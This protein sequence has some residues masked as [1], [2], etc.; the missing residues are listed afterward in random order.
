MNP[1]LGTP[2]LFW[3]LAACPRAIPPAPAAPGPTDEERALRSQVG[4]LSARVQ[5]LLEKQQE[6]VWK[7]WVTGAPVDVPGSYT[8]Q[9]DLFSAA[10]FR[11][12]IR[13]KEI[14]K[15]PRE[16][17]ALE[18]L[19][20]HLAG[21]WL[22]A[23]LAEQTETAANLEASMTFSYEGRDVPYR[24]LERLL[25]TE[26]VATRRRELLAASTPATERLTLVL[27]RKLQ[28]TD[29]L[30]KELGFASYEAFG[31]RLRG[32]RLDELSQ[33]AENVLQATEERYLAAMKSLT[34]SELHVPFAALRASDF[35]YLFRQR[36]TER[37]FPAEAAL[38]R[39]RATLAGL[40]I[41][42]GSLKNVTVDGE[43]RAGK[44]HATLCLPVRVPADVRLSFLP[45]AGA[46]AL[47][48]LFHEVGHALH[49]A[50]TQ[51]PRF[52]LARL[53]NT[54][55]VEALG[56]VF[57]DLV[58]DLQW[59]A[60]YAPMP[61]EKSRAH[62]NRLS[63]RRLYELRRNAA[64][65][66]YEIQLHRW[67]PGEARDHFHGILSRAL[68]VT[69]GAGDDARAWVDSDDFYESADRLRARLLA[70]QLERKLKS[71][72]GDAWWKN[73]AAASL[74]RELWAPGAGRSP[75][76]VSRSIGYSPFD[77]SPL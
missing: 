26:Q 21:E 13:L 7:G 46:D 52:E 43:N 37:A 47:A 14:T 38:P 55:S 30:I 31:E 19:A 33:V 49:F 64:Q 18:R 28:K 54:A 71:S 17:Q 9:G 42:L 40:G 63:A 75:A 36:G 41:D 20:S 76:E 73:P 15:D 34:E 11:T 59:L 66:I 10:S 48:D 23:A 27:R 50:H 25:G 68:G 56:L 74:L 69:F 62:L 3:L 12:V 35:P 51:E 45:A 65:L 1:R 53:G 8:D 16:Q 24:D 29:G 44:H 4:R 57:S 77:L 67:D 58:A 39:V 2:L 61:P 32:I 70:S 6:L 72:F 22:A 60:E 5:A